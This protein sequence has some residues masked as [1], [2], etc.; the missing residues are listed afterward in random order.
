MSRVTPAQAPLLSFD[1]DRYVPL[2]PIGDA[3]TV[4]A[5]TAS[6]AGKDK[7][8]ASGSAAPAKKGAAA[9]QGVRLA[10][11][12]IVLL[13]NIKPE[14][15]AKFI[16]LDK[17]LWPADVPPTPPAEQA[18]V[19]GAGEGE[20]GEEDEAEMPPSFEYPFED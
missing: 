10:G 4:A 16:E 19:Q 20:M 3:A 2:R 11:G 17:S 5:A 1:S 8:P 13:R 14:E 9:P 18:P 12:S 15:E 7:D 6:S